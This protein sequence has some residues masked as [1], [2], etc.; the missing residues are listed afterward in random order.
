MNLFSGVSPGMSSAHGSEPEGI[1]W[2]LH[3]RPEP[4]SGPPPSAPPWPLKLLSQGD[5]AHSPAL[6]I[7]VDV[8]GKCLRSHCFWSPP[9]PRT[10]SP[11][12]PH[13]AVASYV[14][15]LFPYRP[16]SLFCIQPAGSSSTWSLCYPLSD[17]SMAFFALA[18]SKILKI[19]SKILHNCSPISLST[20]PSASSWSSSSL[21][22]YS[23][24]WYQVS[25]YC[26]ALACCPSDHAWL[27]PAHLLLRS[28]IVDSPSS[29]DSFF[30]HLPQFNFA[31]EYKSGFL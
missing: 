8:L 24:P 23:P 25:S 12:H 30:Q 9:S 29:R 16:S 1:Q 17:L 15:S 13:P 14:I 11:G 2:F 27:I 19:A 22:R 4:V 7:W 6:Y 3:V 18:E 28:R 20:S 10:H 21:T 26:C 5:L 31:F